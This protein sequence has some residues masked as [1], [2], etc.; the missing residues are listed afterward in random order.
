[1]CNARG[2]PYP[3]T[4]QN[5]STQPLR[6]RQTN[7]NQLHYTTLRQTKTQQTRTEMDVPA[8]Q[9]TFGYTTTGSS[10]TEAMQAM[11]TMTH[12]HPPSTELSLLLHFGRETAMPPKQKNHAD[13]EAAKTTTHQPNR[14][15]SRDLTINRPHAGRPASNQP[16]LH[17]S[18]R[19]RRPTGWPHHAVPRPPTTIPTKKTEHQDST[20]TQ[21]T[22][23]H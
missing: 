15:G 2:P 3:R 14:S 18:K 6:T 12:C 5:T 4:Q 19:Q 7:H 21:P 10:A 22:N 11:P 1:M 13:H 8:T 17:G 23:Q 16:G 20:I 9:T